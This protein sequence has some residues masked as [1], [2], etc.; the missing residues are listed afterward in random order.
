MARRD[1]GV[2]DGSVDPLRQTGSLCQ[3]RSM[4]LIK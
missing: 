3:P 1:N 2:S 4:G